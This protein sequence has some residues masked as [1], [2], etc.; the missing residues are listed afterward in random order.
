[1]KAKQSGRTA[2]LA[3][4]ALAVLMGS[5]LAG[6]EGFKRHVVVSQE[7]HASEIGREILRRGGNAIDAAVAMAFAL[8]ATLPEA[9]NLGGGGFIVAYLADRQEVV[10]VDF[11]ETA[12]RSAE[13]RMY[14]GTNE[15]PK[16]RC[17]TGAWAAAVPGTVRGLALA[18]ARFGKLPWP[19]LV[20]P[21]AKLAREGF[22]ISDDLAGSLNRQLAPR[23]PD[24]PPRSPRSDFGRLGEYPESIAA[25][26]KPDRSPWRAGDRLVQRDLA[27]TLER[28]AAQ[29][30]DDFYTG[31][32][33]QL[34]ARYMA[35]HQG[36]VTLEDLRAY[37]AK[38]RPAV[39]TTYR[40]VDVYSV[41]PPSS[42]GVVLCQMLNMLERFELKADGPTSPRT[43]HRVA[44]VMKRAFCT[45]AV[46]LGDPDFVTI[47]AAELISKAHADKLASSIGENATPSA[48]LAPFKIETTEH[49]HTTHLSTIDESG[50]AVALTYTLE[51][52]YGAKCV[53]SGAGFLLNNEMGDFNLVPGRTDDRGWIGTVPNQI[54]PGKRMLSSQTPTIVLK[55][56][57]TRVVTGSPGGRTIP[58]TVLWV[59]LYLLEFEFDPAQAVDAPRVHHQWFPDRLTLEGNTWPATTVDALRAK[60][61]HVS[62]AGHQGIAN[63][64]VIDPNSGLRYGVADKRR[65]TAT[66]SGD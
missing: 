59:L 42:G 20:R 37:Q 33:A 21:A 60:G 4:L 16:P 49:D 40:G 52:S 19:E 17:R 41:G 54:A 53:V 63:T 46:E 58:N 26:G 14:L 55:N 51:D 34:I 43:L 2:L 7:R 24:A 5:A 22:V 64:I 10:T 31:Q 38:E 11:R 50:N 62:F 9:G 56:G 13:P 30:P 36:L 61:H 44:E 28:I 8:A 15:K 6:A 66:A 39:H 47:P 35:D 23:N 57:R 1:M 18:H 3:G 12:P 25:F 65:T 45:R 27:C 29:G 32:T 48:R